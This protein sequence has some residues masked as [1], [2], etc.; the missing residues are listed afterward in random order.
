[1]NPTGP[2]SRSAVIEAVRSE[3]DREA[4][5]AAN[6]LEL[7]L[8]WARLH[9]VAEE[10]SAAGFGDV[11][12]HG[13]QTVPL[14]GEG[15]PPVAEFAPLE[16]AAALGIS[17]DAGRALVG[18][19]LELAYRLP[20][21]W[22]LVQ[23]LQVPAWRARRISRLTTDLSPEAATFADRLIAAD[24]D[25]ISAVRASQLVDE[26]RLYFD[27]DRAKADE[28]ND[29]ANRGVWL[30]K[31]NRPGSTDVHMRLDTLDAKNLDDTLSDVAQGLKRLGDRE[32]LDQRR[33]RA[34]GIL[35]NPQAALDILDGLGVGEDA[36]A[37]ATGSSAG[38]TSS[39]PAPRPPRKA[40]LH[41]H[42]GAD[43]LAH[44]AGGTIEGLGPATLQLLR[45]WLDRTDFRIAPVLDIDRGDAVD[46][47]DPPAWLRELCCLR[48]ATCVFP[49]CTVDSRFCD[50]DHIEEYMP[51][52][53]G[54]PPGQTC[55]QNL[56][57]VC[58]THHRLKTHGHW[59]YKRLDD[60]AY[61]WTSPTGQQH[62]SRPRVR[63]PFT[64][65]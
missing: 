22:D 60:G 46:R 11:D 44:D 43:D 21:L 52:E 53:D 23:G 15:T 47:H 20:R 16:L 31:T 5:A 1:M 9:P 64:P 65:R 49:H 27:P 61:C 8:R 50:L 13:E 41:L 6:Q 58:R 63:R 38:T 62:T 14:A 57:P 26:A 12:L 55:A 40:V 4:Q 39:Q 28:D 18:D 10:E 42:L 19:A 37:T 3:R 54:G 29:A 51:L 7:A 34:A 59:S 56:A 2:L 35:A 32:D 24:P 36:D 17:K 48:D 25:H 33:A 45:D 30:H